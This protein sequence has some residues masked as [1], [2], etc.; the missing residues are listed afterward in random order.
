MPKNSKS[1]LIRTIKQ[2]TKE[3]EKF[4]IAE[5]AWNNLLAEVP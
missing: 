2:A 3:L 1:N 5:K 4:E